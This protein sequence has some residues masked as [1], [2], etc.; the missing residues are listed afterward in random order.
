MTERLPLVTFTTM[1][2]A[3]SLPTPSTWATTGKNNC[4]HPEKIVVV[5]QAALTAA[6]PRSTNRRTCARFNT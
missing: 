6:A 2:L 1:A 3:L 5:S 4:R